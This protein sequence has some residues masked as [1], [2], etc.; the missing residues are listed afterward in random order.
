M[1][2]PGATTSTDS[3]AGRVTPMPGR[4]ARRRI[5]RRRRRG[6]WGGR[7]SSRD[8]GRSTA[9]TAVGSLP[10]P[11]PPG[12]NATPRYPVRGWSHPATTATARRG[13]DRRRRRRRRQGPRRRRSSES[14]IP[15]R[16]RGRGTSATTWIAR[17]IRLP[18][19]P[20]RRRRRRGGLTSANRTRRPLDTAGIDPPPANTIG[21]GRE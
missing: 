10:P 6:G 17:S 1:P 8:D 9:T 21:E 16:Y 13:Q 5:P 19:P 15:R 7:G 18:P 3:F 2:L 20:P 11:V 4:D 12:R 14:E